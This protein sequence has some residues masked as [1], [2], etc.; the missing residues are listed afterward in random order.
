MLHLRLC[1]RFHK[2]NLCNWSIVQQGCGEFATQ[3]NVFVGG[4]AGYKS[5]F[6]TL[7]YHHKLD[8][9]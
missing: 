9:N 2:K 4:G 5:K 1:E 6:T 8:E 3:S 7:I